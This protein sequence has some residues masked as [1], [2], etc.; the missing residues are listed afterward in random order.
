MVIRFLIAAALSCAATAPATAQLLSLDDALRTAHGS[1]YANRMAVGHA[2]A[3]A[4][5]GMKALQGILPSMRV[6]P[7]YARTTDPIGAFCP[8]THSPARSSL[9]LP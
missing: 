8:V 2:A 9:P 1:A 3:Q 5:D 6:E 4:G 7:G